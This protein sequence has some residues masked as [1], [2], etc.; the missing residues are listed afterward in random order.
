ML[1]S[2]QTFRN[3]FCP[4]LGELGLAVILSISRLITSK[5]IDEIDLNMRIIIS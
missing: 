3:Y 1:N 5:N 2:S 4:P